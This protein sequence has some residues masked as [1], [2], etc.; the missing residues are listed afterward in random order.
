MQSSQ[1]YSPSSHY[2]NYVGWQVVVERPAPKA[3][4]SKDVVHPS[5]QPTN[6]YDKF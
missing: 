3:L 1:D 6:C 2:P 4:K 5:V